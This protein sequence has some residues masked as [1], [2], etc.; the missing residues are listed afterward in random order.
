M[1]D[2]LVTLSKIADGSFAQD[3]LQSEWEYLYGEGYIVPDVENDCWAVTDEGLSVL[4]E[5]DVYRI[6]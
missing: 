4:R 6:L 2:V 1:S 5:F 3:I